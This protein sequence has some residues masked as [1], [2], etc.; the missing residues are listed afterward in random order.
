MKVYYCKEWLL[1]KNVD[2]IT[3]LKLFEMTIKTCALQ[4][5]RIKKKLFAV[6]F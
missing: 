1:C 6:F 5:Y 4:L 2:S 3:V